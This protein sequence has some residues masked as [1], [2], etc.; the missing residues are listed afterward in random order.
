LYNVLIKI[1]PIYNIQYSKNF[2]VYRHKVRT[3]FMS[4]LWV[5][6]SKCLGWHYKI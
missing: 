2:Y 6:M 1:T 3:D 5:N 4:K